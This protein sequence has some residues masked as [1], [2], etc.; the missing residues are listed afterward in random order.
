M[1][2][3]HLLP[4]QAEPP[5][6]HVPNGARSKQWQLWE[7]SRLRFR[8]ASLDQLTSESV[9]QVVFGQ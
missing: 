2:L 3:F 8:I 4:G 6:P 7:V 1:R 5:L 9:Q